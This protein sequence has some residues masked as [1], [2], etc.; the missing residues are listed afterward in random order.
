MKLS[1]KLQ[2][3]R[4]QHG[5]SQEEL[6]ARLHMARQ[7]ISK[8]ESGQVIPELPSLIALCDLYRLSLDRLV[9]EDAC[10]S[11]FSAQES[12]SED[13]FM[14]FLLRA[15]RATY[16]GHGAEAAP[17]RPASHDFLY[18]EGDWRYQ[19]SY[20]GSSSFVGEE[21]VWHAG[22]PKWSMNYAGRVLDDPFSGDFLKE[23]LQ[24]GT[25]SLP[26]RG[27]QLY[28]SGDWTYHCSAND[29]P[30]WFSGTEEIFYLDQLVY[31]CRFHG[32][33]LT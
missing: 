22:A 23:A 33:R 27:P 16:A 18:E 3:L 12:P 4:Q 7:T 32:S 17:C 29:D 19:D 2:L 13:I 25:H 21:A 8:W 5:L 24:H 31:E 1:N 26:Y 15:K 6:A 14:A 20:L 28:H 30:S 10:T 11:S 9:R